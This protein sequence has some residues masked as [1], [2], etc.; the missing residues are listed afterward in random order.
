MWQRAAGGHTDWQGLSQPLYDLLP[1]GKMY[2]AVQWDI[3]PGITGRR[4]Q[5]ERYNPGIARNRKRAF[6][7]GSDKGAAGERE[8]KSDPLAEKLLTEAGYEV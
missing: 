1:D 3:C 5:R 6:P 7:G 4:D 8:D 2:H